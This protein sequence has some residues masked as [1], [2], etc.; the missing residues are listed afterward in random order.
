M[1]EAITELVY[2]FV[3]EYCNNMLI[4]HWKFTPKEIFS[5]CSPRLT[6][7]NPSSPVIERPVTW[8]MGTYVHR[9]VYRLTE[10]EV[11][12]SLIRKYCIEKKHPSYVVSVQ[13]KHFT[14]S[15]N[16]IVDLHCNCIKY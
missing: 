13:L 3:I 10:G 2:L 9:T 4:R 12:S 7:R 6:K 11:L 14:Q 1:Q 16:T 8:E 15:T 5:S